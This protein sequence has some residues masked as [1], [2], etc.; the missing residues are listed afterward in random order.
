LRII[1]HFWQNLVRRFKPRASAYAEEFQHALSAT[2][3]EQQ[4]LLGQLN[5]LR[6][7]VKQDLS[8]AGLER[9][10]SRGELA[11]LQ[12]EVEHGLSTV[13][14]EQQ[15]LLGRLTSLQAEHERELSAAR[16]EKQALLGQVNGLKDD[17]E[18]ISSRDE[19]LRADL[20]Q[21]F[22]QLQAD[23]DAANQEVMDLR[24]SL[25]EANA[26]QELAG[27]RVDSLELRLREQ[28][29]EHD[30]ALQRALVR[31]RRQARR[32]TAA[33]MVAAAAF[34]LGIAG[35]AINFWE[36]RNT[37]QLLAEVSQGIS[38]I[39]ISMEGRSAGTVPP[40][41]RPVAPAEPLDESAS[42]VMPESSPPGPEG[43]SQ[44]PAVT[45]QG[46]SG[47]KLPEP[48]F[49]VSKSL[50]LDD[51][52]FRSRQDARA[53]FEENSRQPGVITLPSGLQYREL[54]PGTGRSPGSSDQVVVEYRAFRP[55]GTET[56]NSFKEQLPTTFTVDEAIPALKEALPQMQEGAQWELYI[57][58][59][60]AYPGIRKR[61][62]RGFEPLIL[63]VELISVI[64]ANQ[65]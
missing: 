54:I 41:S 50:P 9:Q 65:R 45:E 31:E 22:D 39:R 55:D 15:V 28:Q 47:Q 62:P 16:L 2:R 49:V 52:T 24:A 29:Q 58:A 59:S 42:P 34:V 53:F 64:A 3:Q 48:D 13:R 61:G 1:T 11:G 43:A 6:V 37:T 18:R 21:R 25:S 14:E 19:E 7:E 35:S 32:L 26:R 60:L 40:P 4:S 17:L 38:Q 57:P 27:T 5:D 63:T 33:L 36:V 8:A 10:A 44:E 30:A 51:H 20:Q 23:R 46:L 12:S 56:D